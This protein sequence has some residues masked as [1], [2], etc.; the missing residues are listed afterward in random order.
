MNAQQWHTK[1]TT[2]Q[3]NARAIGRRKYNAGRQRLAKARRDQVFKLLIFEKRTKAE[4]ARKLQV[5][6]STIS[7]DV[8]RL[9]YEEQKRR[10]MVE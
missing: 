8:Q 9:V 2:G 6:P 3:A 4:I 5:H 1:T 7:R 10:G